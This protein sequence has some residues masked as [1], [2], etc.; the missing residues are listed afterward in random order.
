MDRT[1][2]ATTFNSVRCTNKIHIVYYPIISAF[3]YLD[4]IFQFF[5]PSET[6]IHP[7]TSIVIS[8]FLIFLL[9]KALY[10]PVNINRQVATNRLHSPNVMFDGFEITSRVLC[11][12]KMRNPFNNFG[13][14][15]KKSVER[16]RMTGKNPL[17]KLKLYDHVHP[18][19]GVST[20]EPCFTIT[21]LV[22]SPLYYK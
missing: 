7:P 11:R 10:P 9:S 1:L 19:F 5:F 21:S 6:W 12:R 22:W 2:K 20:V 16:K 15:V 13:F 8:D 14:L 4:T 18:D 17:M 3:G